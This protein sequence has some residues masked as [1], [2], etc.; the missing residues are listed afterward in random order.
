MSDKGN[1]GASIQAPDSVLADIV[2]RIV[3]VAYPEHSIL[4]GSSAR[5]EAR[6]DSDVDLLVIA[7]NGQHRGRLTEEIYH[8]LVGVGV[9]IDVVVVTTGD[10]ERYAESPAL[11]IASALREGRVLYGA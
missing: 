2:H 8:A 11:V 3:H 4:F 9:P 6:P 5:G 10:V 7:R 1:A